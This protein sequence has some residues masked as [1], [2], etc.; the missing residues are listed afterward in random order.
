MLLVLLLLLPFPAYGSYRSTRYGGGPGMYFAGS[1]DGKCGEVV[2]LA[3]YAEEPM[4]V[5]PIHHWK[6]DRGWKIA[7]NITT[8]IKGQYAAIATTYGEG[9][10]ILF[11]PH[12]EKK[13]FFG[14]HIEEFPVRKNTRFTW[15]I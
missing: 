14:G 5:A 6:W 15:F 4:E 7:S 9:R 11:G 1:N 13:T 8:D 12:P 2:P 3:V 10:V